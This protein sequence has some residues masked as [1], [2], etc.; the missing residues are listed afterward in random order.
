MFLNHLI[1]NYKYIMKLHNI[2]RVYFHIIFKKNRK[3]I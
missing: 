3:F 2:E 1:K